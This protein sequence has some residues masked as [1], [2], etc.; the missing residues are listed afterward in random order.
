MKITMCNDADI[1][2]WLEERK[3]EFK[4]LK[5]QR[6][7]V[8]EVIQNGEVANYWL[9]ERNNI[10]QMLG[11]LYQK[12]IV[13]SLSLRIKHSYNYS[14]MQTIT[15]VNTYENYDGTKTITKYVFYNVPT[16][17]GYLDIYSINERLGECK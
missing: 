11:L 8:V 3:G 2:N 7:M 16:S 6:K 1:K 17:M 4:E 15:F 13:K 5:E 12:T 9:D 14:D 10:M